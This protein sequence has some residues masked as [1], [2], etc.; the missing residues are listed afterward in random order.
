MWIDGDLVF[1]TAKGTPLDGRNVVRRFKALLAAAG[2]PD[3]R[4]HDLRHSCASILLAQNVPYKVVME[5]LGHSQI[6]LTM[7]YSHV[8]P[9]LRREAADAMETALAGVV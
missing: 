1:R 5:A 6:S 9:E 7:R 8:I 4:W 3:L 2:L